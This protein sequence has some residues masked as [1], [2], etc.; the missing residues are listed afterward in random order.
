MRQL[1]RVGYEPHLDGRQA[2][3]APSAFDP[4][5]FVEDLQRAGCGVVAYQPI[6]PGGEDSRSA[7]YVIRLPKGR[8]FGDAYAA[9]IARWADA[10]NTCPDHAERVADYVFT[11]AREARR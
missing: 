1:R 6:A 11:R 5:A 4:A 8:E 7:S 3:A 10:V 9:V 2:A